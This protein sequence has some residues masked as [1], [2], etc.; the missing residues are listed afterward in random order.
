MGELLPNSVNLAPSSLRPRE[1]PVLTRAW[2]IP[3]YVEA[4]MYLFRELEMSKPDTFVL[5]TFSSSQ[6]VS[7]YPGGKNQQRNI[8]IPVWSWHSSSVE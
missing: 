5:V 4:L 8:T 1:S 3:V 6:F 7:P 2:L